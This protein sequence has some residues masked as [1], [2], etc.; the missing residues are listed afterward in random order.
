MLISVREFEFVLSPDKCLYWPSKKILM[1]ADLHLGKINHFRQSGYPVPARA[2]E[3]NTSLL[4]DMVNKHRPERVIFL[5][6]LFHSHYNQEWEVMGQ[7]IRHFAQCSFELVM[8]NHDIMSSLQYDRHGMIV[9]EA[10]AI[11]GL[12]L[13]HIPD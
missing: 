9:H 1:I 12:W 7:V 13:T 5:G 3:A 4:I 6:D 8:G 2:N 11:E 10:L